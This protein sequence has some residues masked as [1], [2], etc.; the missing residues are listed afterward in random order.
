[1]PL[2][3]L[4]PPPH[5]N[6]RFPTMSPSF[7]HLRFRALSHFLPLLPLFPPQL[8]SRSVTAG[9]HRNLPPKLRQHPQTCPSR[10]VAFRPNCP[11][12][13]SGF[14]SSLYDEYNYTSFTGRF[15]LDWENFEF[16]IFK[17]W[18]FR[19]KFV[20]FYFNPDFEVVTKLAPCVLVNV[21]V[22]F[23]DWF[24]LIRSET[25]IPNHEN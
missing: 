22:K 7:D 6:T 16:E 15:F 17:F 10:F 18:Q 24:A 21:V 8:V 23:H 19:S 13:L 3:F 2:Q 20:E 14:W 1:M 9:S 5:Y 25:C 11:V 4:D 12:K